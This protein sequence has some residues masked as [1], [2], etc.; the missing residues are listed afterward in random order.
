MQCRS[1]SDVRRPYRTVTQR[2]KALTNT[3]HDA[4][5]E[6][7]MLKRLRARYTLWRN[8]VC[9]KHGYFKWSG[10]NGGC[11]VCRDEDKAEQRM[12]ACMRESKRAQRIRAAKKVLGL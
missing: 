8:N 4:R 7:E 2:L 5:G 1:L 9:S 6:F 3:A 12:I 11:G 10:Y